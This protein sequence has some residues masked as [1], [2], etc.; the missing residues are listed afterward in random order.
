MN[1]LIAVVEMVTTD[2]FSSL[3]LYLL[4]DISLVASHQKMN[5]LCLLTYMVPTPLL[6]ARGKQGMKEGKRFVNPSGF[7]ACT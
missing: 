2:I 7:L 1:I 4:F 6:M 5:H 3:Y